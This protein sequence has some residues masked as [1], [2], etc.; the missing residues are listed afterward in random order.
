[1]LLVC[2]IAF[3]STFVLAEIIN[4]VS[5][6]LGVEKADRIS[7]LLLGT[8]K[9]GGLA[10]A[11]AI[12]FLEPRAAVPVAVVAAFNAIHFVWLTSWVKRMR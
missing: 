6:L 9:N 12:I 8:R 2:A 10:G 4:Q 11:I 5:R 7:L 1:L 3:A